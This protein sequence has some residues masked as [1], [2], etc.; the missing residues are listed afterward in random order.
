MMELEYFK[1]H[2]KK[3][4]SY[5]A[6]HEEVITIIKKCR[7]VDENLKRQIEP[8]NISI[9]ERH[10]KPE[11]IEFTSRLITYCTTV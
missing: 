8:W 1:S 3:S 2:N 5:S 11:D 9:C 4:P 6:W 7:V 10:Y